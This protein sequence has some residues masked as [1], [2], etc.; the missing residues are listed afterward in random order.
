[1]S[2]KPQSKLSVSFSQGRKIYNFDASLKHAH[3]PCLFTPPQHHNYYHANPLKV[4]VFF[5]VNL[6]VRPVARRIVR[7]H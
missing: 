6:N 7:A 4:K 2:V 3:P 1:M 5:P